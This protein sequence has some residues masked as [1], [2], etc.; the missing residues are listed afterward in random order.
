MII[1]QNSKNGSAV[2][3]FDNNE[4]KIIQEKGGLF[5]D[6]VSFKHLTK[7]PRI[8]Y[9]PSSIVIADPV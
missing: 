2:I 9:T 3:E 4:K 5:F 1:K 8:K 7:C 6:E